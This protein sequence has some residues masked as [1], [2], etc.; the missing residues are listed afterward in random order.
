MV[1]SLCH[2]TTFAVTAAGAPTSVGLARLTGASWE[3]LVPVPVADRAEERVTC[4]EAVV[5][6]VRSLLPLD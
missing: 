4:L 3:A 1:N 6:A 2:V 5:A